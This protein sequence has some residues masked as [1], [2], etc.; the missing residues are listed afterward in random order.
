MNLINKDLF[1][2]FLR[3]KI[4]GVNWKL[5]GEKKIKYKGSTY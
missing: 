2:K 1:F 4:F 5:M 3:R